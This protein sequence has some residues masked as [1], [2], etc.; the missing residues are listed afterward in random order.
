IFSEFD[1]DSPIEFYNN[2]IRFGDLNFDRY[3]SRPL[4]VY[5]HLF[6]STGITVGPSTAGFTNH[7]NAYFNTTVIPNSGPGNKTL[8]E[9]D[10]RTGPLGTFYYPTNGTQ[11]LSLV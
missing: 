7:H 3:S 1:G 8:T 6:E 10:Y 4:S 5:D 11:L 9:L 2:L